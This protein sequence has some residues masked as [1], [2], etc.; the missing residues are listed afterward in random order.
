MGAEF[1]CYCCSFCSVLAFWCC[2]NS[3]VPFYSKLDLRSFKFISHGYWQLT[4]FLPLELCLF[5]F[6]TYMLAF[7]CV[8]IYV[9]VCIYTYL[10]KNSIVGGILHLSQYIWFQTW[11]VVCHLI[12]DL[13]SAKFYLWIHQALLKKNS[14]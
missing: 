5:Y 9:R 14:F 2:Y 6:K 11:S 8:L 10:Y 4:Y 13:T 7:I 1:W 12:S 3:D